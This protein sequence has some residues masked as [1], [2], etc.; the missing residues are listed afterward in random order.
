MYFKEI[1]YNKNHEM[2][3]LFIKVSEF[4]NLKCSFCYQNSPEG[5]MLKP[6]HYQTC[7]DN[8]DYY[9]DKV[10]AY[11]TSKESKYCTLE[12]IMFGGEPTMNPEGIKAICEH[13]RKKYLNLPGYDFI[14]IS[15]T[16]NGVL[17]KPEIIDFLYSAFNKKI[18]MMISCDFDKTNADK[19]RKIK[20]NEDQSTY[21]TVTKNIELY[22]SLNKINSIKIGS[23]LV[24]LDKNSTTNYFKE[25]E[26]ELK[27]NKTKLKKGF[28]SLNVHQ[29]KEYQDENSDYDKY[30]KEYSEIYYSSGKKLID[31]MNKNNF[32]QVLE[33]IEEYYLPST[34]FFKDECFALTAIDSNGNFNFCNTHKLTLDGEYN[35]KK[36]K[37]MILN[38][39]YKKG[40]FKCSVNQENYGHRYKS[41]KRKQLMFDLNDK[42][43]RY[44]LESLIANLPIDLPQEVIRRINKWI[45]FT[46]VGQDKITIHESLKGLI[47]TDLLDKVEFIDFV[48]PF[49]Y[50]IDCN[51]EI[52]P[53][54]LM[55]DITLNKITNSDSKFNY[56][57]TEDIEKRD[58]LFID[59]L[60]EMN[61]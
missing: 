57:F 13:L 42:I 17:Y 36:M 9:I 29:T 50:Y 20:I 58:K 44:P 43:K 10:K 59:L 12:I 35:P 40:T 49:A 24:D 54:I 25:I 21:D 34:N 48:N 5:T 22:Q 52:H 31:N 45:E 47:D 60:A 8:I 41:E 53:S 14:N 56:F 32:I 16:T 38:D 23:V 3:G 11:R 39:N 15:I 61:D 6:E 33:L 7:F 1:D 30:L 55:K 19:N 18:N 26:K 27:E 28:K 2:F 37:D 4:C 51:Y 46:E